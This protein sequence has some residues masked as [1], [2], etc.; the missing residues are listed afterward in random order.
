MYR[1]Y[2]R[3]GD[4]GETALYSGERVPKDSLRVE[5][6]GTIDELQSSIGFARAIAEDE[7]VDADCKAI[8]GVLGGAMA[9]LATTGGKTWIVAQDV[10][11]IEALCD[12]YTAYAADWKP[13]F[14]VPG[15]SPASAALHVARAIARRAERRVLTFADTVAETEPVQPALLQYLNRVSDLLYAM[16]VHIDFK[17]SLPE[18]AKRSE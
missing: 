2:T 4:K 9:E 3:T 12:K 8:E 6:F 16:A 10:E 15:T 11:N 14:V 18:K 17:R 13:D 7:E 1:Y 5:A